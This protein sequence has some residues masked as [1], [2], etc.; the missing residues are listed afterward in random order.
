MVASVIEENPPSSRVIRMHPSVSASEYFNSDIKHALK[1]VIKFIEGFHEPEGVTEIEQAL[2]N[3][4]VP[5]TLLEKK[6]AK[7]KLSSINKQLLDDDQ[8][9]RFY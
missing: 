2:C 3:L 7:K 8:R 1:A 4:K 6:I 5:E 9:R